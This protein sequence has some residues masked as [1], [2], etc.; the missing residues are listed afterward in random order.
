MV[1]LET[2]S[3]TDTFYLCVIQSN[4]NKINIW[5]YMYQ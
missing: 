5:P 1:L 3:Q 2:G 4:L